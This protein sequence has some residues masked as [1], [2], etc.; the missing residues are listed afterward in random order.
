LNQGYDNL[1]EVR[2]EIFKITKHLWWTNEND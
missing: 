2:D 1:E